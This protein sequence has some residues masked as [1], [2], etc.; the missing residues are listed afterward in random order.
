MVVTP[1][2]FRRER[3]IA[4]PV[5][6]QHAALRLLTQMRELGSDR[7]LSSVAWRTATRLPVEIA[8]GH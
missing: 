7:V 4:P 8:S 2:P 3:L 1:G 5:R 6:S